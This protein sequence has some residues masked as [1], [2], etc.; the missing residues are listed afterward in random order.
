MTPIER[1][2]RALAKIDY[3]DQPQSWHDGA[4]R[5]WVEPARAVIEAIREPSE[6]MVEAVVEEPTH[7]YG[8]GGRDEQYQRDMCAAVAAERFA[9]ANRWGHMIDALLEEGK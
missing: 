3:P 2:A 1:A 5:E 6:G 4:W 8:Q 9:L 7:L